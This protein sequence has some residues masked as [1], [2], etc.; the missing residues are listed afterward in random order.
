V[1]GNLRTRS[2]D[3]PL[4][5]TRTNNVFSFNVAVGKQDDA[6]IQWMLNTYPGVYLQLI[7]IPEQVTTFDA[8]AASDREKILRYLIGRY[9]AYANVF[10]SLRNDT[11]TP[12]TSGLNT[13]GADLMRLDPWKNL[14]ATGHTRRYNDPLWSSSWTNYSHLETAVDVEALTAD[15]AVNRNKYSWTGED[16]YETYPSTMSTS[17]SPYFFRRLFWSYVMSGAGACYG[18]YWDRVQHMGAGMKHLKYVFPYFK[19]RGIDLGLYDFTQDKIASTDGPTANHPHVAVRAGKSYLVYMPNQSAGSKTVL[20]T[21]V[22]KLR[23]DLSR[24]ARKYFHVEWFNPQT[25]AKLN[26]PDREAGAILSLQAPWP[27]TD[28]VLRLSS[29]S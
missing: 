1:G 27:G 9:G 13:F 23:L 22:A 19:S 29:D 24:E 18:G 6:C 17:V 14:R 25:G 16:W 2:E 12:V 28:V 10:W 7:P 5:Y 11:N 20:N 8:L 15:G 26:E 4:W 3:G 21:T